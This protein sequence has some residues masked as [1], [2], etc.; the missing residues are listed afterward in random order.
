MYILFELSR[1]HESLPISEML[2]V[3][4]AEGLEFKII[5][6]NKDIVLIKLEKNKN[7][8]K[9]KKRISMAFFIDE[10]LF[11]SDKNLTKLEEKLKKYELKINGSIAV[12]YKKRS[13]S[14]KSNDIVKLIAK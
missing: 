11:S 10:F 9:V 7:L 6:K 3:L 2:S 13:N 1:E 5:E 8:K 14:I 4:D 12:K